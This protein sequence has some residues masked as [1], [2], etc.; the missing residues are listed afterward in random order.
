M[1][2]VGAGGARYAEF[3]GEACWVL[4]ANKLL[5]NLKDP[6]KPNSPTAKKASSVSKSSGLRDVNQFG[7]ILLKAVFGQL[8]TAGDGRDQIEAFRQIPRPFRGKMQNCAD[9]ERAI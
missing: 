5:Q 7:W 8:W 2:E 1:D 9:A 3:F 6:F 4:R